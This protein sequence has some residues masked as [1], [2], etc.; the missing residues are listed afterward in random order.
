MYAVILLLAIV[1]VGILGWCLY[2]AYEK[3]LYTSY[4]HYA[5]DR[6]KVVIL[7]WVCGLFEVIAF[8]WF[9]YQ[10]VRIVNIVW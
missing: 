5:K 10:H 6:W 4:A 8:G 7:I 2:W 1:L 9:C 3:L